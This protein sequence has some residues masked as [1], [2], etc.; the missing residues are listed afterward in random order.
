[1]RSVYTISH[2]AQTEMCADFKSE[3][4]G[5]KNISQCSQS[6]RSCTENILPGSC[7]ENIYERALRVL[8]HLWWFLWPACIIIERSYYWIN[9]DLVQLTSTCNCLAQEQIFVYLHCKHGCYIPNIVSHAY[10]QDRERALHVLFLTLDM[11]GYHWMGQWDIWYVHKSSQVLISILVINSNEISRNNHMQVKF[12]PIK[13]FF[14]PLIIIDISFLYPGDA[15]LHI[16]H[17]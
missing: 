10:S 16:H 7:T 3:R 4:R 9:E 5:T 8:N 14:F 2:T 12:L 6:E 11:T 17:S 1:M 13:R 15:V